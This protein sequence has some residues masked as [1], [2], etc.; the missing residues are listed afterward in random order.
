MAGL[1]H[2]AFW[3]TGD[4]AYIC[5]ESLITPFPASQATDWQD[6]FKFWHYFLRMHVEQAFGMVMAK[7]E[8]SKIYP[9]LSKLTP[10]LFLLR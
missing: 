2:Y 4:E 1:L 10:I 5:T 9:S 7:G 6:S 3:N 8:L